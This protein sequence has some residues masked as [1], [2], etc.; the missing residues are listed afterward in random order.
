MTITIFE[1][2]DL[3]DYTSGDKITITENNLDIEVF[4][5]NEDDGGILGDPV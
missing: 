4:D 2:A 1:I 3:S 5:E